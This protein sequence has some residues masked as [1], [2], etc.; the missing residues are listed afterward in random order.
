LEHG[1]TFVQASSTTTY[2]ENSTLRI[3][4]TISSSYLD[5]EAPFKKQVFISRIGIYDD[6]ENLIAIATL[7]DPILKEEEQD[8]TFKIK[9]DI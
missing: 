6:S 1:Q 3:K 5:Y 9:L 7:A 8:Y 2:Q 4:N